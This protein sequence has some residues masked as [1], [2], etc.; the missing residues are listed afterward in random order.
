[1]KYFI[2]LIFIILS[3]SIFASNAK[4]SK[5][6]LNLFQA[7][8]KK[9]LAVSVE[10]EEHWHTYWKNPGDAGLSAKFKFE[11]AG[12]ELQVKHMAWPIP[13]RF[14]EQGNITAYGYEGLHTFFFELT[15]DQVNKFKNTFTLTAQ[16]LICENICI[17]GKKVFNGFIDK[18]FLNSKD[19][20][21]KISQENLNTY[22]H[23]LPKYIKAANLDVYLNKHPTKDK[24]L[25]LNY[26]IR[27][28][29]L[30]D[31]KENMNLLTP[32][33]RAPFGFKRE[34]IFYDAKNQ[35]IY[36]KMVIDWDGEYQEPEVE[37][38]KDGVFKPLYQFK[39]LLNSKRGIGIVEYNITQFSLTGQ[40]SLDE[41]YKTLSP[42][43]T[44]DA[45]EEEK[46]FLLYMLFAFLGGM[47]LNLMPC[48]LPVISLKLF[49]LISHQGQSKSKVL[50]HNLSYTL[51]VLVSFIGLA[52][53]VYLL[54]SSG[55][56][57]GW[58]FQMQSPAFL[59]F[60]MLVLEVMAINLFGIFEFHTPGGKT[61]GSRTLSNSFIG[62]F[63]SGVIATILATP[64][65]APFLGAA[66]TFAFT[67]NT[68][69]IFIIFIMIGLG[70][71]FPFIITGF[72]PALISFLPKPGP[73]M[74]KLKKLLGFTLILTVIWLGDV[75]SSL[76]DIKIIG[77][78][79]YS[80]MA[81]IFFAFFIGS[82]ITKNKVIKYLVFL[83]PLLIMGKI[84][85]SKLLDYEPMF[86]DSAQVGNLNWNKWS[87]LTIDQSKKDGKV[88]FI[89]FTAKWCLTCKVNKQIVFNTDDFEK[90]TKESNIELYVADWTKRDP[91]ISK[92]L[93]KHKAAG[94]PI[95]FLL[96]S[97]G[98][99]INFG[100]T[101]SINKIKSAL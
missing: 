79:L 97:K 33:L 98:K 39:F 85:S 64:C 41:F 8:G 27:N 6:S 31:L 89:D 77:I 46:S 88:I 11:Q 66:I 35:T 86:D 60:M 18:N 58:G 81:T 19:N 15:S 25:I 53:A 50:K 83:V 57:I 9:Y 95:Y 67:T 45:P 69:N 40:K 78:Y 75:F 26:S 72:F 34:E 10:N 13:R 29:S 74:N 99:L 47:I 68:A 96:N 49:G 92:F 20:E 80:L 93:N 65:S 44:S 82:K 51:G 12:A 1:V 16:W 55:E 94:V 7:G 62:D 73:W 54:K 61:L 84:Y 38:P 22:F 48:V 87:P 52:L 56:Q 2:T 14:V 17:P 21:L 28:Q 30:G 32:Y 59:L 90:L 70:L 23:N 76:V 43:A 24:K 101:I 91:D 37:L 71:S 63:I 3:F 36:G 4:H 5:S 42:K 100:E